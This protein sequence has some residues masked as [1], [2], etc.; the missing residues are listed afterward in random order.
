MVNVIAGDALMTGLA[1]NGADITNAGLSGPVRG[2]PVVTWL[3]PTTFD[4]LTTFQSGV[5]V[6]AHGI[7]ATF[8]TFFLREYTLASLTYATAQGQVLVDITD[9]NIRRNAQLPFI[10]T[11]LGFFEGND[12]VTGNRF[13]DTIT[14]GGGDDHGAGRLGDDRI[15]GGEG[16]DTLS[17]GWGFDTLTGGFDDDRLLGGGNG[18]VLDGATGNDTLFGAQGRDLLVGDMDDDRLYGG[19]GADT[20]EGGWGRDA[21]FGGNDTD[22]DV[23]DFRSILFTTEPLSAHRDVI[24][25]MDRGTDVIRLTDIDASTSAIGNQKF[26][27]SGTAPRAHGVWWSDWGDNVMIR[28]DRTGDARAD[29]EILVADITRLT[30]ADFLL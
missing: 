10:L 25:G 1:M 22:R 23:F 9:L 19:T 27:F 20:L 24:Y 2:D 12:S 26:V 6:T 7:R 5:T 14:L 29:M 21:L 16:R 3:T 8:D 11:N 4:A 15:D 13:A 17:G 18:D 28:M 30:A